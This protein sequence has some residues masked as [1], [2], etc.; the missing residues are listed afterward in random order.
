MATIIFVTF[1]DAVQA[2]PGQKFSVL[3]GGIERLTPPALPYAFPR[4][5]LLLIMEFAAGER[6]LTFSALLRTPSGEKLAGLDGNIGR[7][8]FAESG[9]I[10]FGAPLPMITFSQAGVHIL[11][12]TIGESRKEFKLT[13]EAPKAV[14]MP[15]I[16]GRRPN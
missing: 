15:E 12:V 14:R 8:R 7:Q 6:E 10:F 1:A 13:V 2:V 11:E 16:R 9:V 3:G 4:L 5:D